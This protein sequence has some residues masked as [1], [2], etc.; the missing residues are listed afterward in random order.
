MEKGEDI[1]RVF[2]DTALTVNLI[3]SE[4]EKIGIPSLIKNDFQSGV[5][6]GFGG[7]LPNAVDLYVNHADYENALTVIEEF[8]SIN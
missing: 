2:S 4:L 3:K 6:A 8:R 1:V 7:G 5:I